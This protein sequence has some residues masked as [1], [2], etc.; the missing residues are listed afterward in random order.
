MLVDI[1][2]LGDK[3]DL[4]N[5]LPPSNKLFVMALAIYALTLNPWVDLPEQWKV[6]KV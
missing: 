3:F 6:G 5:F 1:C 2:M 4:L